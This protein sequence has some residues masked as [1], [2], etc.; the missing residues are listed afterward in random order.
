MLPAPAY[1]FAVDGI[2]WVNI[3]VF[4]KRLQVP[5]FGSQAKNLRLAEVKLIAPVTHAG[6]ALP[7]LFL[8]VLV[9]NTQ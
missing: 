1:V 3:V 5:A 4:K 9:N 8:D 2:V 6:Q 7:H